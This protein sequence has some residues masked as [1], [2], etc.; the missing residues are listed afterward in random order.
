MKYPNVTQRS[1]GGNPVLTDRRTKLV[2]PSAPIRKSDCSE[3]SRKYKRHPG[4]TRSI[5]V[6]R[7]F[8][9]E[10]PDFSAASTRYLPRSRRETTATGSFG[11]TVTEG[12][13][14]K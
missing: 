6:M 14:P 8:N 5:L 10:T 3:P 12:V 9:R 13:S 11:V 2:A 7:F 1:S 4:V